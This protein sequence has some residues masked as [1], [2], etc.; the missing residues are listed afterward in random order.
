MHEDQIRY[1]E[2]KHQTLDRRIDG[3]EKTGA[4]DDLHLQDLK[5]QRLRLRDEI[6]KLTNSQWQHDHEYI[7]VDD[8]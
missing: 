1:L 8:E 4:F 3:L 6:T 2:E 7:E 5:K